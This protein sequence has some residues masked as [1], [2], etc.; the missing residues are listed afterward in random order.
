MPRG[1]LVT[2]R[3]DAT[4]AVQQREDLRAARDR[5]ANDHALLN[6]AIEALPD[7]FALY[8]SEDRL[9]LCNQPYREIYRD[10]APAMIIGATF[11]SI[12]RYGLERG[13]Y[14][15]AGST[16]ASAKPGWPSACAATA[17]PTACRCCRS[18]PATVGCA[19]TS[20]ARAAVAW[21][22]CAPT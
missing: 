22:A 11:E 5:A 3:L 10:S 18:C 8:D 12:V 1:G 7:G 4:E 19:S 14:P 15:Q 2:V 17:N 16:D 9:L 20:G 13:Q 21:P 6:D